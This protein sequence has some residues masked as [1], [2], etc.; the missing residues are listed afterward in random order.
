MNERTVERLAK[1]VVDRTIELAAV[2]APPGSEAARADLVASWWQSDGWPDVRIDPVGNVRARTGPALAPSIVLAA[3]LDTVFDVSQPHGARA[4][5]ERLV[6]PSVGDNSVGVAALSAAAT[7]ADSEG[8]GLWLVATVGEEGVGNLRGVRGLL[9]EPP[10]SGIDALIAVEGNYLGRVSTVGVGATRWRVEMRGPGGHAWEASRAPSAVLE[11]A[12]VTAALAGLSLTRGRTS[13]N[14]GRIA[15]GE[16]INARAR[17]AWLE[18][19]LRAD[20][21]VALEELERLAREAMERSIARGIDFTVA[22]IGRR[23]AGSVDR[24]HPLARA[25]ADALQAAGITPSFTATSTDANA[26]HAAGIPSIAIGVTSG[27]GEH[28]PDEWIDLRPIPTGLSV[29]ADTAARFTKGSG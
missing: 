25:A 2:P 23:P 24:Q 5:D 6:G 17:A 4:E 10:E 20:D 18:V 22:E 27:E 7:I 26:G 29:L 13:V 19:D 11:A 1:T 3:H 14:V 9:D 8:V 16:A 15:G 21:P 12:R 28:T